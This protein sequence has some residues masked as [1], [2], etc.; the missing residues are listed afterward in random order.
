MQHI[1]VYPVYTHVISMY[2]VPTE[3][4]GSP[5]SMHGC[6]IALHSLIHYIVLWYNYSI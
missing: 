4:I 6:M 3:C 2:K 5:F 1:W